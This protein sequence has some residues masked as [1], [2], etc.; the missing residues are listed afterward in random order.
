MNKDLTYPNDDYSRYSAPD[1]RESDSKKEFQHASYD[2]QNFVG[3]G[4]KGYHRRDERI[5]E[6]VCEKLWQSPVVDAREIEVKVLDGRV[7]LKGTVASKIEKK[8]S[9]Y[10]VEEVFGVVDV[11]NEL[12]FN[13]R[14]DPWVDEEIVSE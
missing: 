3:K 1:Y 11:F 7:F 14:L 13:P 5:L 10:L 2:T 12:R 4:P 9:E 8:M 6:E